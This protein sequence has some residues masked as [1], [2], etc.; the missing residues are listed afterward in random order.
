M[1]LYCNFNFWLQSNLC[2]KLDKRCFERIK[3]SGTRSVIDL[4]STL[5]E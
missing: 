1:S 3:L 4:K 5:K 2:F